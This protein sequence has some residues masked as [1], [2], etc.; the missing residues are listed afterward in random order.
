[1]YV[2]AKPNRYVQ[3]AIWQSIARRNAK[4]KIG[5]IIKIFVTLL[6]VLKKCKKKK[7]KKM[8]IP[9]EKVLW[10]LKGDLPIGWIGCDYAEH[11]GEREEPNEE[12]D[13]GFYFRFQT[14]FRR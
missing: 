7:K 13:E 3:D 14:E 9:T 4:L 5:V 1:M 10:K 8:M 11:K 2:N 12:P 6:A